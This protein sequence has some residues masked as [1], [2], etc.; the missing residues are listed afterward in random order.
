MQDTRY[1]I[2]VLG[3]LRV[4]IIYEALIK[5]LEAHET[6]SL[7]AHLSLHFDLFSQTLN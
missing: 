2:Q 7:H 3:P 1:K 4:H 5:E 6:S